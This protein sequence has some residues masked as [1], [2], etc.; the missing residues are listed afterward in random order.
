MAGPIIV[1]RTIIA[2]YALSD[3]K[4]GVA[5]CDLGGWREDS[6]CAPYDKELRTAY[7]I[8]SPCALRCTVIYARAIPAGLLSR[9]VT[10][11]A[12]HTGRNVAIDVQ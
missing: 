7:I 6:I 2:L 5:A 8:F 4:R 9:R 12:F 1:L 3:G 10:V 11:E